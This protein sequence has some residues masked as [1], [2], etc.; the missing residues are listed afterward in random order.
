MRLRQRR[1][2]ELREQP[3]FPAPGVVSISSRASRAPYVVAKAAKSQ[4]GAVTPMCR[5]ARNLLT[6][7]CRRSGLFPTTATVQTFAKEAAVAEV[8]WKPSSV[9]K[10]TLAKE[11]ML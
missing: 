6:V 4:A 11:L 2:Q 5:L 1:F 7:V 3:E 8:V 9:T 10:P